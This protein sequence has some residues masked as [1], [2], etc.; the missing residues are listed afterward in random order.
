MDISASDKTKVFDVAFPSDAD[1]LCF[2]K[3]EMR[4]AIGQLLSDNFYWK[5]Q[6]PENMRKLN[7]IPSTTIEGKLDITKEND[8]TVVTLR[9]KNVGK[10]MGVMLVLSL[11]EEGTSERILPTHYSD[12]YFWM[13]PEEEKVIKMKYA[14]GKRD[15]KKPIVRVTGYNLKDTIVK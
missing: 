15:A 12:N 2:V 7:T 8:Q 10:S 13:L 11:V 3:L 14:S 1:S 6:T 5:Y 4:N 9:L